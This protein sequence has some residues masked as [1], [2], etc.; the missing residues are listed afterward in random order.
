MKT[1]PIVRRKDIEK[2]SDYRTKLVILDIYDRMLHAIATGEPYQT[3]LLRQEA[4]QRKGALGQ[5]LERSLKCRGGTKRG[6]N[7]WGA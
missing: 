3:F 4:L 6:T 5:S 1:F 7:R 2:H